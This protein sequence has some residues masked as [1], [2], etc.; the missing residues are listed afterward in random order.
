ME[1]FRNIEGSLLS[2]RQTHEDIG[3]VFSKTLE[4]LK[5]TN[6]INFS[7]FHQDFRRTCPWG[8]HVVQMDSV[9]SWYGL[10][11][12]KGGLRQVG[13]FLLF[14]YTSFLHF[15]IARTS[16]GLISCRVM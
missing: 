14:R 8:S 16:S 12:Q 5:S 4:R 13:Y 9:V 10:C 6:A 11:R 1:F 2:K 3:Q 7:Y 15:G